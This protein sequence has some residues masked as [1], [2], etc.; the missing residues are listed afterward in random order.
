MCL[1]LT[2]RTNKRGVNKQFGWPRAR[3]YVHARGNSLLHLRRDGTNELGAVGLFDFD[4]PFGVSR[5]R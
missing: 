3:N 2:D 5:E 4:P 1:W